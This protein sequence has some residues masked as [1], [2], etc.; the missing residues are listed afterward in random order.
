V[1]PGVVAAGAPSAKA[2]VAANPLAAQTAQDTKVAKS[3]RVSMAPSRILSLRRW[4][5]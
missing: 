5:R 1:T 2:S 4:D 3:R